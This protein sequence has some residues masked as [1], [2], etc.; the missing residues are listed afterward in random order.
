M[1]RSFESRPGARLL[2]GVD[3]VERLGELLREL[4]AGRVLLVTDPGIVAAGH[5][6]RGADSIR[7]A[8]IDVVVHDAVGLGGGSAMDVA[9][10]A[11]FLLAGGGRM[12]DYLGVGK[13]RGTLLPLVAVP[14]TAG[15]GSEMQ[16]F[17]LVA[18]A[19]THQKMA[20]GD[21]Q[22]LPRAALLDP[23][24]TTTQP[25][26]VS[27]CTGLDAIG[28]A[29]ETAVTRKRNPVSRM[30]SFE[31]FRLAN[32][33]LPRVL[34]DPE[35]LV[36]RG[37]MLL[38]AAFAGRAIE[39]SMLGELYGRLAG[40]AGLEPSP[41]ALADRLTEL[42]GLAGLPTSLSACGVSPADAPVLGDEAARQWTA[43]F[44]PRDVAASDFRTL[45]ESACA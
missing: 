6:P 32:E 8:G 44:N 31:A 17:A 36:A 18:D 21:P 4:G 24:L 27:A 26:P 35:D 38:A 5:A 43:Q 42:L 15:T 1:T 33:A 28:H 9:K 14:T 7:A 30:Y 11:N 22:A 39:N 40:A 37:D 20:C 29:V 19:E 34:A 13:A 16:S 25:A 41:E 2:F 3:A 10:G 45:F 12:Q 23:G